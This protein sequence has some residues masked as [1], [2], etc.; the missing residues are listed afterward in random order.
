MSR[1]PPGGCS[2]AATAAAW[3]YARTK[4]ASPASW[5]SIRWPACGPAIP[6]FASSPASKGFPLPPRFL[7][8]ILVLHSDIPPHAPPEEQDTLI[9]AEAVRAA[10][11]HK[12]YTVIKRAFH[13]ETLPA[14]LELENPN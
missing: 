4:T 6:T 12:G 11:A 13:K 5:K 9:A 8:K 7:M 14:L 10:L 2:N 3:T 1:S